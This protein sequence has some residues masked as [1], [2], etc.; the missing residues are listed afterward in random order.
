MRTNDGLPDDRIICS[1]CQHCDA[2]SFRCRKLKQ[3]TL[4]DLPRRCVHF[5]PNKSEGDQR[6][7]EQR[8]PRMQQDIEEV[9]ALDAAHNKG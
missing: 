7:G 8:W 4:L 5:V 2:G 1:W 9:R 6:T 3:G